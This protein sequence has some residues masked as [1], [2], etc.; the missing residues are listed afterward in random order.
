MLWLM[1][2]SVLRDAARPTFFYETD[3]RPLDIAAHPQWA[4]WGLTTHYSSGDSPDRLG[5]TAKTE[6]NTVQ[7]KDFAHVSSNFLGAHAVLTG[8]YLAKHIG[9]HEQTAALAYTTYFGLG[10]T[11]GL[12]ARVSCGGLALPC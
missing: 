4:T 2:P 12:G 8:S 3:G 6:W 10:Q 1:W 5:K 7:V 9:H 11:R